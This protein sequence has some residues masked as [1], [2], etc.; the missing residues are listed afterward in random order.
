MKIALK[1]LL[2]VLL[3]AVPLAALAAAVGDGTECPADPFGTATHDWE[4]VSAQDANC[5]HGRIETYRCGN[6][7]KTYTSEY[8]DTGEHSFGGLE[9]IEPTCTEYGGTRRVCFVCGYV[10]ELWEREPLGHDPVT[11][12]GCMP[13]PAR[14]AA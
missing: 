11:V 12:P 4:L 10:E 9:M 1:S 7:G 8:G 3:L 2:T 14:K 5:M 6:C 13:P